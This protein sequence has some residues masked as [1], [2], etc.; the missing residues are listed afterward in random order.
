MC[1]MYMWVGRLVHLV[2]SLASSP[3]SGD[4]TDE[5]PFHAVGKRNIDD[6]GVGVS[7]MVPEAVCGAGI[8]LNTRVLPSWAMR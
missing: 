1:V 7:H 5:Q 3:G 2:I 8:A 4:R 6:Q